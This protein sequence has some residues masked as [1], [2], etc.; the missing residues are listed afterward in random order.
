MMKKAEVFEI[1]RVN[2]H[3]ERDEEVRLLGAHGNGDNG[4]P[5]LHLIWFITAGSIKK[6]QGRKIFY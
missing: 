6:L 4:V 3:V 5:H 2:V 1:L